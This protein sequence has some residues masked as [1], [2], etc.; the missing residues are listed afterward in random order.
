M[1]TSEFELEPRQKQKEQ[2]YFYAGSDSAGDAGD[3][4]LVTTRDGEVTYV[5]KGHNTGGSS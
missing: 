3:C 1:G 5:P 2:I 4:D